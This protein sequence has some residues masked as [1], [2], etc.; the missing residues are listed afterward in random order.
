M[1][2]NGI[3]FARRAYNS[4]GFEKGYNFALFLI[5]AGTL[6][7]FTANRLGYLSFDNGLCPKTGGT[8]S[9]FYYIPGSRDKLGIIVHLSTIFPACLLVVLQFT[10]LV[11]R[12]YRLFHRINGYLV[13]SLSVISTFAAFTLAPNA[14]GGELS[15]QTGIA[16]LGVAFLS[17]FALAIYYI[18]RKRVAEH[19]AWML[20]AWV[21]AGS[22]ITLRTVLNA[23]VSFVGQNGKYYYAMPC[24]RVI[25]GMFGDVNR[26]LEQYPGCADFFSGTTPGATVAVRA[27]DLG[28]TVANIAAAYSVSFGPSIWV[29]LVLHAVAVE[30]YLSLTPGP[31]KPP[32]PLLAGDTPVPTYGSCEGSSSG[33]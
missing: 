13:I 28:G 29:S 23:L 14:M 15:T 20:R 26:T 22:I 6:G 11:R 18:R 17:S 9:C 31:G 1:A 32:A 16:V 33:S 7:I 27:T 19:R 5:L 25:W 30:V 24:D 10:P 3:I 4:L 8:L 12:R 2:P 21:Y